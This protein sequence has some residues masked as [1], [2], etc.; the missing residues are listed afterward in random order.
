[1]G[2]GFSPLAFRILGL[3]KG[4]EEERELRLRRTPLAV[5]IP[6]Q[7]RG[8]DISRRR[9]RQWPHNSPL[10]MQ[11]NDPMKTK[12]GYWLGGT[13]AIFMAHSLASAVHLGICKD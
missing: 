4:R 7:S 3:S 1:M 11:H 12:W 8:T 2:L 9:G 13:V 5:V 10:N 6:G